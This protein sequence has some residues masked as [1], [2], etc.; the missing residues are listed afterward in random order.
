MGETTTTCPNCT[1]PLRSPSGEFTLPKEACILEAML[2]VLIDRGHT[3]EAVQAL[4]ASVDGDAAWQRVGA[5]VDWLESQLDPAEQFDLRGVSPT[6][7]Q[8]SAGMPDVFFQSL[9]AYTEQHLPEDQRQ[10]KENAVIELWGK[11]SPTDRMR[12]WEAG[13]DHVLTLL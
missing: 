4:W 11:A 3:A 12:W 1:T 13:W 10:D 5:V 2:R 7:F 6:L 9:L 8:E